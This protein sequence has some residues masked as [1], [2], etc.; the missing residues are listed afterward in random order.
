MMAVEIPKEFFTLQ[1]M[2]TLTGATGATYVVANG[3]Q[4]AFNFNPRWLALAIA[5]LISLFGVHQTGGTGSDYFV[6][7]INGF[8]IFCTAA[9]ATS[10]AGKP[11]TG[12]SRGMDIAPNAQSKRHFSQSWF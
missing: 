7:V 9:G 1:S 12:V 2:L 11:S 5:L 3:C 6:G 8:L 4:V 10:L